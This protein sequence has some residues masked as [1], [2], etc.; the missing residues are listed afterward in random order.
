MSWISVESFW[1]LP[2]KLGTSLFCLGTLVLVFLQGSSWIEQ[3]NISKYLFKELH[4]KSVVFW[5]GLEPQNIVV[6]LSIFGGC[7]G[8]PDD[9]EATWIWLEMSQMW[10]V[11]SMWWHDVMEK[12]F[13]FCDSLSN[14]WSHSILG[15]LYLVRQRRSSTGW[16]EQRSQCECHA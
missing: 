13:R 8:N 1:H 9:E 10:I 6:I 4:E 12:W 11:C 2:N 7:Q 14:S 3:P 15:F 5:G 16:L